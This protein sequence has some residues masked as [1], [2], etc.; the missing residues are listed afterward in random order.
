MGLEDELEE[1]DIE[2]DLQVAPCL[3]RSADGAFELNGADLTE[4]SLGNHALSRANAES[5]RGAWAAAAMS[6]RRK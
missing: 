4:S 2:S 3:Q 1:D 6:V 5:S